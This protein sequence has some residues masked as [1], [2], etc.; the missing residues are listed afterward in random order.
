M[1]DEQKRPDGG[2]EAASEL[3]N[4]LRTLGVELTSTLRTALQSEQFQRLQRD[5]TSGVR[6]LAGQLEKTVEKV[7][8]DPRVQ[9]A[10]EKGRQALRQAQES[11]VVQDAEEI[12]V[13]GIA[14][15][16]EQLRQLS[17]RFESGAP[18]ESASPPTQRVPVEHTPGEGGPDAPATGETTKLDQ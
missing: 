18:G 10:S 16:T 2:Q 1:G 13:K 11:K 14:A 15:I 12:V 9:E 5:L 17:T 7:Q 3:L 8:T 6:E 4:A